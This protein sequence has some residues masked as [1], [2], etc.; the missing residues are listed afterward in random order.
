MIKDNNLETFLKH[1]S[2]KVL[3]DLS[4][5]VTD[6]DNSCEGLSHYSTKQASL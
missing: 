1:G 5:S 4:D 6:S 2:N 3:K